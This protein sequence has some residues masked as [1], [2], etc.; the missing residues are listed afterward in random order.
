MVVAEDDWWGARSAHRDAPATGSIAE[1]CAFYASLGIGE[2]VAPMT[3][4]TEWYR[5]A[6]PFKDIDFAVLHHSRDDEHAGWDYPVIMEN[7]AGFGIPGVCVE[8][9]LHAGNGRAHVSAVV[10]RQI[11]SRTGA[12][13]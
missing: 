2:F 5:D 8:A 9:D 13:K 12:A 4:R 6:A 7:L 1:M 10:R 11:E 3:K